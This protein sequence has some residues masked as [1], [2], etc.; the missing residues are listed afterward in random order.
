MGQST[1]ALLFWGL[2]SD[3]EE[4]HWRNIGRDPDE[5]GYYRPDEEDEDYFDWEPIYASKMGLDEPPDSY[6][7]HKDEYR[8]YREKRESLIEEAGCS[9]RMHCHDEF[10]MPLVAVSD[11]LTCANRG[12]PKEIKS[13]EVGED[14]EAKLKKFCEIMGIKWAEPKWWLASYWG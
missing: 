3:E 4:C 7:D 14:W 2:C 6:E 13:M 8:T 1:D 9:I 12:Y 10:S 11:S 5:A